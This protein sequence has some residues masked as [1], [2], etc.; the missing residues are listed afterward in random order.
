[1]HQE[2]HD[3]R[4][5]GSAPDSTGFAEDGLDEI[6]HPKEKNPDHSRYVGCAARPQQRKVLE[7]LKQRETMNLLRSVQ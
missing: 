3:A 6:N 2:R 4:Q 1:M 5:Q 7:F